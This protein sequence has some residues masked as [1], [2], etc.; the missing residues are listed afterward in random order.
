MNKDYYIVSPFDEK[1]LLDHR[2]KNP[3]KDFKALTEKELFSNLC[4]YG[5]DNSL[6]SLYRLTQSFAN[7]SEINNN[8]FFLKPSVSKHID[9]LFSIREKLINEG[10]ISINQLYV[11]LLKH[12]NIY[13]PKY[14]KYNK[15]LI[16]LLDLH[17]LSYSFYE[18]NREDA[19]SYY[20]FESREDEIRY[21]IEQIGELLKNNI[22]A[23][24]IKVVCDNDYFLSLLKYNS[25]LP[26]SFFSNTFEKYYYSDDFQLF[27]KE[28]SGDVE[29]TYKKVI[30]SIKNVDL[31]NQLISKYLKQ[32]NSLN[33]DEV[34][35]FLSFYA[36]KMSFTLDGDIA[37]ISLEETH[38]DDYVLIPDFRLE[39]YPSNNK[40]DDF[41]SDKEKIALG[42]MTSHEKTILESE[43]IKHI[44]LSLKHVFISFSEKHYQEQYYVSPLIENMSIKKE[45]YQ[46]KDIF[47]SNEHLD[48]FLGKHFDDK[49]KFSYISPYVAELDE[50]D[51]PYRNYQHTFQK[52]PFSIDKI[53]LSYT[54]IDLFFHCAFHYYLSNILRIDDRED[55]IFSVI[56]TIAHQMME[57]L[58][59]DEVKPFLSYLT[60][61]L[62]PRDYFLISML[63]TPL[64]TAV[65]QQKLFFEKSPLKYHYA[66]KGSYSYQ[67]DDKSLLIGKIDLI[68]AGNN[69][70][71]IT[72][73]KTSDFVFDKN[74]L[75]F[76]LSLQ[77]PLYYL[78]TQNSSFKSSELTGLYIKRILS[79]DYKKEDYDYL[80]LNGITLDD[81]A[82]IEG[83]ETFIKRKG[84]KKEVVITDKEEFFSYIDIAKKKL[85]ECVTSIEKGEFTINPK[86]LKNKNISCEYCAFKDICY[87]DYEDN[88]YLTPEEEEDDEE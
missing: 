47:F 80:L 46:F 40:D 81:P 13:L 43:K 86:I 24:K 30:S 2:N 32:K 76:G 8:L 88:I 17:N 44:L 75:E 5:N 28:Y 31:F 60:K 58:V 4:Y 21:L 55:T 26:F 67:I 29:D 77:L 14:Q 39:K 65:N 11:E 68:C 37:C 82:M 15:E 64:V 23:S 66:E 34:L 36:K 48:Y 41:L 73:Y 63:E 56:G 62:S 20:S 79:R 9:E 18:D 6:I 59:K 45:I 42:R 27:L 61:D 85:N 33:N 78:L 70:Y 74:Q 10:T 83:N 84:R 54:S 52:F 25:L 87:H 69:H 38:F 16:K 49:K 35:P 22:P 72:D 3:E 57:D 12:G 51:Y 7:A 19:L 50:K 53:I 1:I 71:I